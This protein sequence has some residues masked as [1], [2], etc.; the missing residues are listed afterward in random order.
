MVG[1]YC[2]SMVDGGFEVAVDQ[3]NGPVPIIRQLLGDGYSQS[4]KTLLTPL[5]SLT[6]L[7]VTFLSKSR[8]KG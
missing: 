6:I 2:I 8:S 7:V 3:V 4:K 5:T 1:S